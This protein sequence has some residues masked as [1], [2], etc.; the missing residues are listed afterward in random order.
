MKIMKY[1]LILFMMGNIFSCKK[2]NQN[3]TVITVPAGASNKI[4]GD[5]IWGGINS[6]HFINQPADFGNFYAYFQL[7]TAYKGN[8]NYQIVLYA[9]KAD[10]II[11]FVI[12]NPNLNTPGVYNFQDLDSNHSVGAILQSGYSMGGSPPLIRYNGESY[13][14]K[15]RLIIDTISENHLSG[16]IDIYCN[17]ENLIANI[18]DTNEVRLLFHFSGYLQKH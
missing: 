11:T 16:N 2:E 9:Q 5:I 1:I 7:D 6:T 14:N 12:L 8:S 18:P 3:Q 15:G 10:T 17:R 13:S 4:E